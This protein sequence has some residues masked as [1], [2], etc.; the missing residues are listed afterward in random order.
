MHEQQVG[1]Q[2][3]GYGALLTKLVASPSPDSSS[4]SSGSES[5]RERKAKRKA[6]KSNRDA[7]TVSLLAFKRYKYRRS[8]D[9]NELVGYDCVH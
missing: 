2:Y 4:S 8:I 1:F 5:E 6:K 9:A 3:F 7:T